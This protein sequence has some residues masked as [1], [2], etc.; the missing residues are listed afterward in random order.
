M[1]LRCEVIDALGRRFPCYLRNISR[2]GVSARGCTGLR[3]GQLLTL[4]LPV[5]GPIGGTVRWTG[6]DR[7]GVQLEAEIEPAVLRSAAAPAEAAR[8]RFQLLPQHEPVTDFRRPGLR[9][10]S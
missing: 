7:F 10:A 2:Q 8:P 9:S 6:G 5:I 3:V 4:V 1:L